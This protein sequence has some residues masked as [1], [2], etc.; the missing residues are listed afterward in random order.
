META[1]LLLIEKL[2][3]I[4]LLYG[5]FSACMGSERKG[6]C[7]FANGD[8]YKLV[9]TLRSDK[10]GGEEKLESTQVKNV[11]L[12]YANQT[13]AMAATGQNTD[14]MRIS[15]GTKIVFGNA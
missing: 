10:R 15:I 9:A 8:G 6:P 14:F 2:V 3:L 11:P 13:S 4:Q 12:K 5:T 7:F 1:V